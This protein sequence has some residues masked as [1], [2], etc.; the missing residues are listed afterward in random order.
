MHLNVHGSG[1][2]KL[3]VVFRRKG[4][5][6]IEEYREDGGRMARCFY[7]WLALARRTLIELVAGTKDVFIEL[8]LFLT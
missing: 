3:G 5:G 8:I 1:G 2:W 6:E 4:R 7:S